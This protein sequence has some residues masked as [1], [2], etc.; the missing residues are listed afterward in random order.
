MGFRDPFD[1]LFETIMEKE[2]KAQKEVY[3]P[4]STAE[5]TLSP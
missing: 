2:K 3:Q 1:M 5:T 4:V